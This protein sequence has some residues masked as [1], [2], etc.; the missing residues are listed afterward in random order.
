M[1]YI[2]TIWENLPSESTP[3]NA[4]N[5]NKME[6]GIYDNSV[7]I[8]DLSN[9]ETI[10]KNNL[11]DAINEN[12]DNTSKIGKL[13]WQGSFSSGSITVD[14][15]T[16]YNIIVVMLQNTIPC[17][18]TSQWGFGGI[19]KFASYQIDGY[20]YRFNPSGNTLTIDNNNKGGT[21][22]T[23]NI[24]VTKIYGLF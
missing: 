21:D 17:I 5:L 3:I 20:A 4:S 22:G 6:N 8:G 2:K 23:Q 19:G 13:L 1:A 9:L 14:G 10:N 7:N 12:V 24:P 11:V 16:N 18:G 15:L